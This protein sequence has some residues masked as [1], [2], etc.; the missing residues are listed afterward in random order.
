MAIGSTSRALAGVALLAA[1][2]AGAVGRAAAADAP[3]TGPTTAP[4]LASQNADLR[5][6][7][8][9]MQK[10]LNDLSQQV[11][12]APA[13]APTT[14]PAAPTAARPAD[15]ATFGS[16]FLDN[17]PVELPG[18]ITAGYKSGFYL[19]QGDEFSLTANGVFDVRYGYTDA[20]NK[21]SLTTTPLGHAAQGSL[22]GFSL[23]NG[24]LSLGGELFKHGQQDAFFKAT[25]N[26]GTL[27]TPAGTAGGVFFLNEL[28]G[29]YAFNDALK[30]RAGA[31][32]VPLTPFLGLTLNG[33]LT[34]P[35]VA[36]ELVNFLPGFALGAD[37][38]GSLLNSRASWD[39]MVNNG[40]VGQGLT[41]ST[42]V[43]GGRD[44]R[45]GVYTREQICG[46][47]Q[48]SDFL[49]ESDVQDHQH[50]VWSVGG[51]FGYE[52]QNDT[53]AN[54]AGINGAFPGPQGTL[55]V[56]GLSSTGV[57]F[58]APYTVNGDV[59]RYNVDVRAKWHGF[60]FVGDGQYEN[61]A[62]ESGTPIIAGFPHHSIGQTGFFAQAG[63][64]IIP[65]HLEI[66][67]RFGQ[68]Y[69]DGLH[70]EFQEI[71]FGFNY[72]LYGENLKLQVAETYVP[73]QAALT[74]NT[75]LLLNTQDWLTQ[76][77]VQL[78]F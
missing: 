11:G 8:D 54:A 76:A 19:K 52:S 41:N 2:A 6:R 32:I 10:Q 50:F 49:D 73:H 27:Q 48:L 7:V 63:Y 29:G 51:G 36:N 12:H 56:Q 1:C 5:Q 42:S 46:S 71:S 26:F 18:D 75:G 77:Q 13:V 66:D 62:D 34:F 64:F 33:G 70:H 38:G 60:S 17:R 16:I 69:T 31:M 74:T 25:G 14:A 9:A 15:A 40:S 23:Y 58:L 43:L 67:G 61:V 20:Q 39:L 21:T 4:D 68:L 37:V 22:S 35:T 72:Y 44:N 47:G 65:K 3:P 45:V 57:G 28:Y 59:L 30:F 55:R 24:N 53:S 78:K